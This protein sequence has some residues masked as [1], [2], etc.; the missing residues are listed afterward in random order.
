[1]SFISKT[2]LNED[3]ILER[4]LF[5]FVDDLENFQSRHKKKKEFIV[6]KPHLIDLYHLNHAELVIKVYRQNM[7]K[8]NIKDPKEYYMKLYYYDK[9]TLL[10]EIGFKES[11]IQKYKANLEYQ[12]NL[13][14]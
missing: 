2:K 9:E 14:L 7:D 4:D 13:I 12:A 1:M 5:D 10:K 8:E 11:K 6:K 3:Y